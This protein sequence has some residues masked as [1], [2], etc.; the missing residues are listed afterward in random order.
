MRI[1]G[2][3]GH[4]KPADPGAVGPG[5]TCEADVTM[6]ICQRLEQYMLERGHQFLMTHTG[7]PE[8]FEANELCPRVQRAIDFGADCF[9]SIHCNGAE[10]AQAH[11]FE[12]YALRGASTGLRDAI[13]TSVMA[14][15]PELL[16]RGPKVAGFAVM[17]GPFPSALIET[18]FITNP[19]G[20]GM[21]A[22]PSNQQRFAEAIGAGICAFFGG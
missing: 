8:D 10:A 9:V 7:D 21:L 5:G 13:H 1:A 12:S 19:V 2:D 4:W 11:G 20:E 22:D 14:S 15:M 17:K 16:D 18:E 6:A 3:P